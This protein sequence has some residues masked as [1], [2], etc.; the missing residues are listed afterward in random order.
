MPAIKCS[1][2]HVDYWEVIIYSL[3]QNLSVLLTVTE[4][5]SSLLLKACVYQF[6][7]SKSDFLLDEQL[8]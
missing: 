6:S 2:I 7:G 4:D 3:P 5:L 1:L 8:P